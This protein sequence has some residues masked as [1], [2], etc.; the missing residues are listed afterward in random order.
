LAGLDGFWKERVSAANGAREVAPPAEAG[1]PG[2]QDQ[3]NQPT[4]ADAL[5]LVYADRLE[6]HD[7]SEP[8]ELTRV[9][10][11]PAAVAGD[12]PRR[13]DLEARAGDLLTAHEQRRAQEVP[14]RARQHVAFR[15]GLVDEVGLG[16]RA[17]LK[18]AAGLS[19]RAPVTALRLPRVFGDPDRLA[20]CPQLA[21]VRD[22]RPHDV[23][24]E[25]VR[26]L[27]GSEHLGRLGGLYLESYAG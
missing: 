9:Q 1:Y 20:A 24:S 21:T 3:A 26:E 13:P 6:E 19:R 5:R 17:L 27:L 4:R 12:D 11:R 16:L 8:A 25:S 7:G 14:A 10:C 23:R 22:L 18:G 2:Q 15:R